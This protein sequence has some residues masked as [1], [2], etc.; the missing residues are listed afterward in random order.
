[1]ECAIAS[2]ADQVRLE[3][4]NA[5]RLPE[6]FRLE[7]IGAGVAGLG[8]VRALLPR[9]SSTLSLDHDGEGVLASVSLRPP[10]LV[11]LGG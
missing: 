7:R 3:I 9:R 6:D 8:L 2:E 11:R 4:R 5:G 10:S 1:M